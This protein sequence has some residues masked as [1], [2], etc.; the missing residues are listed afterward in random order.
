MLYEVITLEVSKRNR[1]R[2][3]ALCSNRRSDSLA[4]GTVGT[5]I[6]LTTKP[7]SLMAVAQIPGRHQVGIELDLFRFVFV[8]LYTFALEA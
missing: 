2:Q 6:G 4:I 8:F 7:P 3:L 1:V 5:A